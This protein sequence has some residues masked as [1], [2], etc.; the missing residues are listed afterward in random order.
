M[1]MYIHL[2]TQNFTN[3]HFIV[4]FARDLKDLT[5]KTIYRKIKCVKQPGKKCQMNIILISLEILFTLFDR[6]VGFAP[7]STFQGIRYC[8]AY[9]PR[10]R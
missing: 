3:Y 4:Q 8:L 6:S 1:T 7:Y 9:N 5:E 2:S 10:L